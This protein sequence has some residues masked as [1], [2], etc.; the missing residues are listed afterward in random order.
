MLGTFLPWGSFGGL[1]VVEGTRG[2][3][4]ITLGLFAIALLV[5][6][7]G[8]RVDAMSTSRLF[9]I[10]LVAVLAAIAAT[11]DFSGVHDVKYGV[12]GA[13]LYLVIAAAL[14]VMVAASLGRRLL[15]IVV[16][17]T[18]VVLVAAAG[19]VNVPYGSGLH[20]RLICA[21]NSWSLR[22]T[23]P[24]VDDYI[25]HKITIE[26]AEIIDVLVECGALTKTKDKQP[27]RE[28]PVVQQYAACKLAGKIGICIDV[29]EC[30]GTHMPGL[31]MGP[32]NIQCCVE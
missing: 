17:M 12:V 24:N 9:A 32:E 4:W 11:Y 16:G 30:S 1:M 3:G 28:L 22:E 27:E 31:C 26:N 14:V 19:F 23:F 5:A 2:D 29:D 6:V 7:T 18:A 10:E 13:G 15:P 21:K 25:G 8:N 20:S